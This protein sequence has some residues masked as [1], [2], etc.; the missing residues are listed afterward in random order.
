MATKEPKNAFKTLTCGNPDCREEF[1]AELTIEPL[2]TGA[3]Y[4]HPP[5]FPLAAL[6]ASQGASTPERRASGHDSCATSG[7]SKRRPQL[8]W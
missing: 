5:Y 6:R 3:R 2:P 7:R 8:S 1:L 4:R